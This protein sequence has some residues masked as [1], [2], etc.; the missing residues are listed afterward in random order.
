[1]NKRE[2][3]QTMKS[4]QGED[5]MIIFRNGSLYEAYFED[6]TAIASLLHIP[7]ADIDGVPTIR[8]HQDNQLHLINKIIDSGAAV[9]ISAMRDNGGEYV[10][11]ISE[12]PEVLHLY[13]DEE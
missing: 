3:L 13:N 12:E 1:M 8:I 4:K 6:A 7:T 10:P 9:C 11:K 5:T 2:M